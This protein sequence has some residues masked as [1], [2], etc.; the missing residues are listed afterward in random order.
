[1]DFFPNMDLSFAQVQCLVRGLHTLAVTDGVHEREDALIRE[2][3][4]A[5]RPAGGPSYEDTVRHPFTIEDGLEHLRSAELRRMFIKTAWLLAFADGKITTPER[6]Q[7]ATYAQGLGI[8][9]ADNQELQAQ[10]KEFLL[11]KLSHIRNTSS[12]AEVAK[13]MK[14]V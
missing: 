11:G 4:E 3:F 2:F 14:I 8:S 10:V 12:L 1:M 13:Q 6:E 9:D 5:C 7:I